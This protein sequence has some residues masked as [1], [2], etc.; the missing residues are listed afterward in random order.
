MPSVRVHSTDLSCTEDVCI[1]GEYL[2]VPMNNSK[3]RQSFSLW[4]SGT[5][6]QSLE[7]PCKD[8]SC[9]CGRSRTE[10]GDWADTTEAHS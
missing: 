4:N 10:T 7:N 1:C 8:H 2:E 5:N 6:G 9:A 3:G